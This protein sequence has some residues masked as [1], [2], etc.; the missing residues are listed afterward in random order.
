MNLTSFVPAVSVDQKERGKG[1]SAKA[2]REYKSCASMRLV[3]CSD[4]LFPDRAG[5]PCQRA[6]M[7]E[8]GEKDVTG[9]AKKATCDAKLDKVMR[10]P[11]M[12]APGMPLYGKRLNYG[13]FETLLDV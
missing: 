12:A 1:Q 6:V 7:A 4:A 3:E 5:S 13:G 11:Q 10:D 9:W 2:T 8:A